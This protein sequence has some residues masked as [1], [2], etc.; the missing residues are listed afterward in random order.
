MNTDPYLED[1]FDIQEIPKDHAL[2]APVL[3]GL[4]LALFVPLTA[5]S[6]VAAARDLFGS[7]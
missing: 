1:D 2:T 3:A 7:R 6:F 4:G 5:Y